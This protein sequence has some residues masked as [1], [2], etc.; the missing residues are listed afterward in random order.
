MAGRNRG[1]TNSS[2]TRRAKEAIRF[3]ECWDLGRL[4]WM[5]AVHGSI[6]F[7][8]SRRISVWIRTKSVSMAM[9]R[10]SRHN[11][12]VQHEFAFDRRLGIV[13]RGDRS[14]EAAIVLAVL[15]TVDHGLCGEPVPQGVAA[16]YALAFLRPSS[17]ALE[18]VQSVRPKLLPRSHWSSGPEGT[19]APPSSALRNLTGG[20]AITR[21]PSGPTS[22]A[23]QCSS[24]RSR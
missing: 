24:A 22:T 19:L 15:Q 3:G 21:H 13:V 18:R 2:L 23:R 11:K 4:I 14:L 16:R 17:G 1:T 20:E 6:S 12:E 5:R 8:R 10:R 7:R 9:R